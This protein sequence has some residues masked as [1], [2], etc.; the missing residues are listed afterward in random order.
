MPTE[1]TILPAGDKALSDASATPDFLEGYIS[2]E[3]YAA[4]RGVSIRTA[5]RDRQ[6]RQSP[7]FIRLGRKIYYRIEGL[8]EWLREQE[9]HKDRV[10]TA[11]KA[12]KAKPIIPVGRHIAQRSQPGE[13]QQQPARGSSRALSAS[14]QT[15]KEETPP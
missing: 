1:Q 7:P 14:R 11:P 10:P 4:Q 6:L 5:Q 8:K 12:N 3:D 15:G 2:E 9:Q 13:G